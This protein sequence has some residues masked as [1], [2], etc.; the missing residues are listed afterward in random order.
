MDRIYNKSNTYNFLS[1]TEAT[2]IPTALKQ[3]SP[4]KSGSAQT[5][6]IDQ[7]INNKILNNLT[8]NVLDIL[9]TSAKS[10]YFTGGENIYCPDEAIGFIYFPE[11][12]VFSEYK[13]N[14]DGRMME[15][16]MTGKEGVTGFSFLLNANRA[17]NFTQVLQA[18]YAWQI[19]SEFFRQTSN[20][21]ME[22]KEVISNY[23]NRL[24]NQISQR[25]VCKGFHLTENSLCSWLLMLQERSGGDKLKLTHEQIALSLGTHRPSITQ[26][27]KKLRNQEIIDYT[28][29]IISILSSSKLKASA[30]SCYVSII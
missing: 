13:I 20:D 17:E 12:A 10:V 16:I 4:D 1:Q 5:Y 24:I 28:R 11:T 9:L 7:S 19:D 22:I 27:M 29:G 30:C 23:L 21:Y 8:K 15:I 18:G 3:S 2:K 26:I 6:L 14:E 25:I